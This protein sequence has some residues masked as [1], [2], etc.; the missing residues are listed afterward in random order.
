MQSF[1]ELVFDFL[2]PLAIA[3]RK[4]NTTATRTIAI[5]NAMPDFDDRKDG[6]DAE[7]VGLLDGAALGDKVEVVAGADEVDETDERVVLSV[8]GVGIGVLLGSSV[9]EGSR[10]QKD[11]TLTI[12][13]VGMVMVDVK[14]YRALEL[15]EWFMFA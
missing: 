1:E 8:V 2:F 9:L 7:A 10:S 12:E 6:C 4:P 14:F 13:V 15:R 5:M 3:T 11:T